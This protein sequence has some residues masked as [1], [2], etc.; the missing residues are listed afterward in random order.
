MYF[1]NADWKL[2]LSFLALNS[3]TVSRGHCQLCKAF[4]LDVC[5][6]MSPPRK[7]HGY[8]HTQVVTPTAWAERFH[9][10]GQLQMI[11]HGAWEKTSWS[12]ACYRQISGSCQE[13]GRYG[14]IKQSLRPISRGTSD[15]W[16]VET[17]IPKSRKG[18]KCYLRK[19]KASRPVFLQVFLV[20]VASVI[21]LTLPLPSSK[22]TFS[23]HL[24]RNV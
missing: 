1:L 3:S 13:D 7:S 12:V 6:L 23:Q 2:A 5:P 4:G 20:G 21:R 18:P 10:G 17:G 22:S 24:K 15:L 19:A 9:L 11:R 8:V 14:L 16:R